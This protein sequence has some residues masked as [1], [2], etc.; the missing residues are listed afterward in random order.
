MA[1]MWGVIGKAY[2]SKYSSLLYEKLLMQTQWEPGSP[3][4]SKLHIIADGN[5]KT[6]GI[7]SNG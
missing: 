7:K 1:S 5:G 6:V 2:E 3:F 4:L